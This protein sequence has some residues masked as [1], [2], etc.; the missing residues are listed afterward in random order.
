[1][2]D[3][4]ARLTTHVL[5]VSRGRPA[6]GVAIVVVRVAEDGIPTVV[7]E[8]RTN[9]DGR[10][11]APLVEGDD[12]GPGRYELTFAVGDHFAATGAVE[13]G[14]TPY[15]DLVPVH[16]GIGPDTGAVHVALLVTPWSYSTYRGS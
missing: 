11:D 12:F 5:D 15:L 3:G 9:D 16:V 13:P 4:P 10:T 1:M 14:T 8:V 2:T 6:A 7:A